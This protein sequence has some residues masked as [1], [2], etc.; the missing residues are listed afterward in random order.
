MDKEDCLLSQPRGVCLVLG[1]LPRLSTAIFF[2][3]VDWR[4]CPAG[5]TLCIHWL[6]ILLLCIALFMNFARL[7]LPSRKGLA[8]FLA[9]VEIHSHN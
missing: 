5:E 1:W 6:G 2:G 9:E 3:L 7:L 8:C 4:W